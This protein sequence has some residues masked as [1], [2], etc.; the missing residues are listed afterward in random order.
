[1]INKICAGDDCRR[2][3]VTWHETVGN[4]YFCD[5]CRVRDEEATVLNDIKTCYLRINVPK[6]FWDKKRTSKHPITESEIQDMVIDL[7]T[8][9]R[10]K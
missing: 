9:E 7:N 5:E 8:L 4:L 10:S 1:M 6:E 3:V 2:T